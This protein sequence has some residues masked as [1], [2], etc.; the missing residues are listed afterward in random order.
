[1]LYGKSKFLGLDESYKTKSS[2]PYSP[3]GKSDRFD[4]KYS[5]PAS[6]VGFVSNFSHFTSLVITELNDSFR[7]QVGI[8]FKT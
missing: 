3:T 6:Q 4:H 1:M 8:A 7:E 5:L 2:S